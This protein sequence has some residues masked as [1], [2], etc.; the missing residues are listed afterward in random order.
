MRRYTRHAFSRFDAKSNR[1]HIKRG[2]SFSKTV[3]RYCYVTTR[4]RAMSVSSLTNAVWS[5]WV[6][7]KRVTIEYIYEYILSMTVCIQ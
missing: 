2:G 5:L 1:E 4:E 7:E 6:T 3:D